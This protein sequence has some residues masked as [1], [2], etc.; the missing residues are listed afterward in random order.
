MQQNHI[1]GIGD[2]MACGPNAETVLRVYLINVISVQNKPILSKIQAGISAP[3]VME[4]T[5]PPSLSRKNGGSWP[6]SG[7]TYLGCRKRFVLGQ[8]ATAKQQTSDR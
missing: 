2:E 5:G 1:S 3:E 7:S 4:V 6:V 8:D